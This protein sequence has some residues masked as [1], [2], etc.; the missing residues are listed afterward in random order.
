M[1][2]KELLNSQFRTYVFWARALKD[3]KQSSWKQ[4]IF[5]ANSIL[6]SIKL[7]ESKE[8]QTKTNINYGKVIQIKQYKKAA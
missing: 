5:T 7:I 6:Q 4:Y 1:N 3:N 8:E 2:I